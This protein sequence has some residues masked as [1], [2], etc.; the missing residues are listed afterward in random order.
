LRE[1]LV[2]FFLPCPHCGPR[3]VDEYAYSGEVTRRPRS[4][5]T[6]DELTDYVYFRDNVA[7]RQREWWQHR[8]GCGEWFL[9]ERDTQTN[10]VIAVS[11][12]EPTRPA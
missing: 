7:G 11:L 6:L 12:P 5:P 1:E 3:P 10:E 4:T 2:S 8:L 9:A